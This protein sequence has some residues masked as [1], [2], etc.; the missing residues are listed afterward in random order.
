MKLVGLSNEEVISTGGNRIWIGSS[1]FRKAKN[2][3]DLRNF[4]KSGT[5]LDV[6][7]RKKMNA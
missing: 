2:F 4:S 6:G 3:W 1:V 7:L 5:A